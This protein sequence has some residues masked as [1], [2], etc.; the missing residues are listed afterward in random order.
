MWV[1][2]IAALLAEALTFVSIVTALWNI[3]SRAAVMM[4][5]RATMQGMIKARNCSRPSKGRSMCGS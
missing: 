3:N 1:V 4:T 2:P 5:I